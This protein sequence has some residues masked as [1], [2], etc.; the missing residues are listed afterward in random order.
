MIFFMQDDEAPPHWGLPV[1]RWL[2]ENL[3]NRWI[4]RG[5][6]NMPWP[7]R[8]ADFN[9]CDFFLWGFIKSKLYKENSGTIEGLERKIIAAFQE[10]I[11]EEIC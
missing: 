1:R 7:P 10:H 11:T 5:S 4:D 2:D 3:A 8:S 9:P 6:S